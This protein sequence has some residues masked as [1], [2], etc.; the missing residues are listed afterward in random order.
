[1]NGEKVATVVGFVWATYLQKWS[2]SG[3]TL[4]PQAEI[5][6]PASYGARYRGFSQTM[7]AAVLSHEGSVT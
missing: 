6:S 3:A 2:A 4:F 7:R 1:M 5:A